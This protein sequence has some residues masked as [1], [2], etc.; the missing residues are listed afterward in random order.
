M[1]DSLD[2][3]E[4][5]AMKRKQEYLKMHPYAVWQSK[6]G[7][8]W[9]TT[10]PDKT[11]E[12]GVRQIRRNSKEQLNDAIVEY[13]T[14]HSNE[15]TIVEVFTEW[16]DNRIKMRK[17]VQSSYIATKSN[18]YRHFPD[19]MDR[20]IKEFKPIDWCDF[21]ENCIVTSNLT[22][23]GFHM[24]K[25]TTLGILKW[26]YKRSYIDYPS[27]SVTELLDISPKSFRNNKKEDKDEVFSE[28]ETPLL[29]DYF[30]NNKT[31][32]NL[33]LL[34]LFITG[35][36]I[37]E[38]ATLKHS[39]FTGNILKIRR[40]RTYVLNEDGKVNRGV[41]ESPKSTC[42]NRDIIVP[43]DFLWL[44]DY[45]SDGN[46]DD[47]IF[48]SCHGNIIR[49]DTFANHLK[50]ACEKVGIPYRPPHKIRKTYISILLDNGV[51]SKFVISQSGHSDISCAE[52][53]YH[54]ER[55]NMDKKVEII[56]A[57][58]DFKRT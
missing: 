37:G 33:G 36:R 51:D 40:T 23:G 17:I 38:L 24:L 7:K 27:D 10:L 52:N 53:Y 15:K 28:E 57:I 1:I 9:Y 29:I 39:D 31:L 49:Q 34:L 32:I 20:S 35:I 26:A 25:S 58:P 50:V 18:F 5:I 13:W 54:K 46:P 43:K 41:K 16:N 47:Y 8:Y 12:R 48:L 56:N 55:K 30:I 19:I 4:L 45:F 11:K 21:L 22:S 3:D 44:M 42:G 14:V 6:D 2:I